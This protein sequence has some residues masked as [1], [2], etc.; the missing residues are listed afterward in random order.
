MKTTTLH[1]I[2]A[3]GI[4]LAAPALAQSN[5][6][7]RRDQAVGWYLPVRGQVIVD[8]EKVN[9]YEIRLYREN[10]ELGRVE[11]DRRGRFMLEL[12]IDACYHLR[13]VK[14]GFQKKL[15]TID[16]SLPADLVKYPDYELTVSLQKK[17]SPNLDPFY[18]DFPS[19]IIRYSAD[20]GGFYHNEHYYTHLQTKLA[21][22]AQA[23]P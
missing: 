9:S 4:L 20:Y 18:A 17:S 19:A 11:S 21:G 15:I 7:E 23:T 6:V 16:T 5:L 22:Y 10:V 13:F 8:G 2:T 1:L 3:A 12:D 14:D